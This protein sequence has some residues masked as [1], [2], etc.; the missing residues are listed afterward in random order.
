[1]FA[2][3]KW[4]KF[5][6]QLSYILRQLVDIKTY[7]FSWTNFFYLTRLWSYLQLALQSRYTESRNEFVAQV[8]RK[9]EIFFLIIFYLQSKEDIFVN[10]LLIQL[11]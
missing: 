5:H 2:G 11:L 1:M 3:V 8:T 4:V 10:N 7:V 9:T 6:P